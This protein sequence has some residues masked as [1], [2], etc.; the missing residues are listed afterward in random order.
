MF[1]ASRFL[2][3]GR[4]RFELSTRELFRVE[5][6][7]SATPLPLGSRAADVLLLFLRRPGELV[8]KDEIKGEVWPHTVVE[9]NNLRVQI[10]AL[11]HALDADRDGASAISTVPGR[12]YRFT[13]PVQ[14][15]EEPKIDPPVAAPSLRPV[16]AHEV[17]PANSSEMPALATSVPLQS[18][19]II[20]TAAPRRLGRTAKWMLIGT[21]TVAVLFTV[22][23]VTVKPGREPQFDLSGVWQGNDGGIY[24]IR[25][26]G[27][28]VT[29]EAAS[30]D[31]VSWAHTFRG[32]I[33]GRTVVGRFFDHPP[34]L[35]YNAGSLT[36]EIIDNNRFEKIEAGS[37]FTG[38]VWTRKPAGDR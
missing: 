22:A 3:S 8:T 2:I 10:S 9:E 5:N 38:S 16:D 23:M 34:G 21:A 27:P 24:T 14:W 15:E 31:G 37:P 33:H 13:L 36:V 32:E 20:A 4:F 7:G 29:W 26:S 30:D 18:T 1:V 17:Q 11:R 12:G 25:Q 28:Q 19:A 6:D 35:T